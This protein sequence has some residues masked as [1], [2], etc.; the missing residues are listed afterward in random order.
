MTI[1][2]QCP[3]CQRKLRVPEKFAG[4]RAKCPGCQRVVEIPAGAA[5][6]EAAPADSA[7][8]AA[9]GRAGPA[10]AKPA[11]RRPAVAKRAEPAVAP[12]KPAA[13]GAP[14]WYV[15][16]E[17]GDEYGP[18]SRAELETWI[19]EGRVDA[20][21]QVFCDGWPDWK[22]AAEEFPQLAAP[23]AAAAVDTAPVF[24]PSEPV[25]PAVPQVGIEARPAGGLSRTATRKYR[26][27]M[28]VS[29]IY[30]VLAWVVAILGVLGAVVWAI[31]ALV[32]GALAGSVGGGLFS[33]ILLSGL[34]LL[35]S[36]LLA[37]TLKAFAELIKLAMDIQENTQL[38]AQA[39]SRLAER[40]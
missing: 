24:T 1:E 14:Q 28:I 40:Q 23:A 25:G 15:H 29:I 20:T 7:A 31:I 34:V 3:S 33:A 10:E 27:L 12:P 9:S 4:K 16:T 5:G 39:V 26:A 19:E 21:C 32:G 38:T 37:I 35:Y 18:V 17:E 11:A 6:S 30:T 8:A 13:P 2:I 36:F 22:W